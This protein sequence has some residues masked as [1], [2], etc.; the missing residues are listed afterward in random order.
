MI[1]KTN[2]LI[3]RAYEI[4]CAHG[5]HEECYS[6]QH[7]LMLVVGEVGEMVDADRRLDHADVDAFE[8]RVSVYP[9]DAERF[10]AYIKDTVEDEM[11]DVAIRLYDFAG[12]RGVVFDDS[13]LLV[14]MS[15]VFF[16][17]EYSTYTFAEK[18][19]FLVR[20]LTCLSDENLIDNVAVRRL[21]GQSLSFLECWAKS[22]G[23]DLLWHIERKMEYNA[24]RE[25]L[26][27]KAY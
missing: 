25:M 27:G 11:A 15:E 19:F 12:L 10:K 1:A 14:D 26:H 21:I 13:D 20:L 7:Y 4:A 17:E 6:G 5:F 2:E 9:D 22:A 8:T 18:A 16:R 23:I 3:A 24:T